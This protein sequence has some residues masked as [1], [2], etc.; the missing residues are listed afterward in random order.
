MNSARVCASPQPDDTRH[1]LITHPCICF[2]RRHASSQM[3]THWLI[4]T[5]KTVSVN[6]GLVRTCISIHMSTHPRSLEDPI[7]DRTSQDLLVICILHRPRAY[8]LEVKDAIFL[9]CRSAYEAS[10]EDRLADIGIGT[11][12]LMH[13]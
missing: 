10:G 5:V 12:D 4:K 3:W 13:A 8:G 7:K 1:A 11:E 6:E 9:G 2:L